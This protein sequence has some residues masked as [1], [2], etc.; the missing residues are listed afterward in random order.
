MA[1]PDILDNEGVIVEEQKVSLLRQ[2]SN[3]K[4]TVIAIAACLLLSPALGLA[5]F[6]PASLLGL[7]LVHSILAGE[8]SILKRRKVIIRSNSDTH[9]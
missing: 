7:F 6:F 8:L 3:K 9:A 1:A 4:L 5:L 2:K